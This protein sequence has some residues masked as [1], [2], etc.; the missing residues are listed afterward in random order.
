M[1]T[2]ESAVT[3]ALASA[4]ELRA[5]KAVGSEANTRSLL[6]DPV[7]DG[8]GW[9]L[10]DI[11]EVEREFRVYDGTLLDYALRLDGTPRL[12]IEAK[13][14]NKSLDDKAFIAQTVNYANNEG[15]VWCVLTNGLLYRVY[16]TN[17]PVGMEQKLLFEVDL[18]G[19]SRTSSCSTPSSRRGRSLASD[20]HSRCG[21]P[22]PRRC[23]PRLETLRPCDARGDRPRA[24][25]AARARVSFASWD[26]EVRIGSGRGRGTGRTGPRC[27]WR[28]RSS[29]PSW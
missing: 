8:L 4:E 26:V 27:S 28:L 11:R 20:R 15:V 5:S 7:L 9:N 25:I 13:A 23:W 6:I 2:L 3:G 24:L 18:R 21:E 1:P 12:F 17:E 16:K 10:R 19:W 22:R 14:A 29:L